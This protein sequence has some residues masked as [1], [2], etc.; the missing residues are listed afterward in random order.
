MFVPRRHV[1]VSDATTPLMLR[2]TFL[3]LV[4]PVFIIIQGM[5]AVP[6]MGYGLNE[7]HARWKHEAFLTPSSPTDY[8]AFPSRA[9]RA[10]RTCESYSQNIAVT[11]N[12]TIPP[13]RKLL[14]SAL[15]ANNETAEVNSPFP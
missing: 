4:R 11:P 3:E 14:L 15:L 10:P 5:T 2:D 9:W 8:N 6:T 7:L 1:D 13:D 12:R